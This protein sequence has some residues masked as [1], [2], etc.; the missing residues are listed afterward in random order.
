MANEFIHNLGVLSR[1]VPLGSN[2]LYSDSASDAVSRYAPPGTFWISNP[3]NIFRGNVAAGSDGSGFWFAFKDEDHKLDVMVAAGTPAPSVTA[4]GIFEDNRAH[5]SRHG[6]SLDGGPNGT[7]SLENGLSNPRNSSCTDDPPNYRTGDVQTAMSNYQPPIP[8]IMKRVTAYKCREYGFWH[9]GR[10]NSVID[11]SLFADN[12]VALG[13]VFDTKLRNS[14]V[15][16]K[17]GN[18]DPSEIPQMANGPNPEKVLTGVVIY[19]GPF[20]L[21]NVQFVNFPKNLV[22][23]TV[24]LK[25]RVFRLTVAA[26]NRGT[27]NQVKGLSFTNVATYGDFQHD[28]GH[29]SQD[30]WAAALLDLDGSLTGLPDTSVVPNLPYLKTPLCTKN[31]KLENAWLCPGRFGLIFIGSGQ[32]Q[33]DLF[34][35]GVDGQRGEFLFPEQAGSTPYTNH[36]FSFPISRTQLDMVTMLVR[37]D[38]D[39]ASYSP[40]LGVDWVQLNEV[41]PVIEIAQMGHECKLHGASRLESEGGGVRLL[42]PASKEIYAD[43]IRIQLIGMN[44]KS[45][46]WT[47]TMNSSFRFDPIQGNTDSARLSCREY[48]PSQV[49][50]ESP[51]FTRSGCWYPQDGLIVGCNTAPWRFETLV[52]KSQIT[53]IASPGPNR[54]LAHIT[55]DGAPVD[56]VNLYAPAYTGSAAFPLKRNGQILSL[57]AGTHRVVIEKTTSIDDG[58]VVIDRV[59]SH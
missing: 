43:S 54:G 31:G 44:P 24:D 21:E 19:D 11:D 34:R 25:P 20:M 49:E 15:V 46:G 57:P 35:W 36:Q 38:S 41:S 48:V 28:L 29:W 23:D 27:V 12:L 39:L 56:D 18:F 1:K 59:E 42:Y 45:Y 58:Y 6:F 10:G 5:S 14:V 26:S 16:G 51:L 55:V 8:A 53:L 52:S 17:S 37:E 3:N 50:A 9:R 22:F 47:G 7:C 4:L 32:I 33:F 2:L 13:L 40:I 30:N